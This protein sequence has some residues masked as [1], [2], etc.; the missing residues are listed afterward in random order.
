MA[1]DEAGNVLCVQHSM[2]VVWGFNRIG[3][4]IW[5]IETCASDKLTNLAYGGPERKDLFILD[6]NGKVLVSRMPVP[7]L[8]M[9]AHQ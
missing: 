9:Y 7:G 1:V 3:L 5:R 4:P 2:G 8:T 6:G